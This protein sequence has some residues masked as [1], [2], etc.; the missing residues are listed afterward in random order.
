MEE[1]LMQRILQPPEAR[2]EAWHSPLK[3]EKLD[4]LNPA[5]GRAFWIYYLCYNL[6]FVEKKQPGEKHFM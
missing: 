4:T 6:P 3:D 2:G 1:G 5:H